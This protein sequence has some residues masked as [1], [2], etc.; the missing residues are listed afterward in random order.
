MSETGTQSSSQCLNAGMRRESGSSRQRDQPSGMDLPFGGGA[1]LGD[2]GGH[3]VTW[4]HTETSLP[5]TR[6]HTGLRG[7][8]RLLSA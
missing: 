1:G 5:A 7:S 2:G 4:D 3:Q 8:S 6:F